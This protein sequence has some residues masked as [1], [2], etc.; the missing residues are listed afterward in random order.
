MTNTGCKNITYR[1]KLNDY[2]VQIIRN[3]K[4]F[5]QAFNTLAEA[6]DARDKALQFYEEFR[7]IPSAKELGL[8]RRE[9][10]RKDNRLNERYISL[11]NRDRRRPYRV[12]MIKHGVYFTAYLATLEEAIETRDKVLK[13]FYEFDRLPNREEQERLLDIKYRRHKTHEFKKQANSNT[14]LMNITFDET[15]NRYHIQLTRQHQK[16][17]ATSKALEDAIAIRDSILKFYEDHCRLPT[18]QEYRASLKKGTNL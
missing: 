2:F 15:S 4:Q 17:S 14:K 11:A 9:H 3:R 7:R 18:M 5:N 13:F 8:R 12:S 16:F 10:R 1:E 6:I